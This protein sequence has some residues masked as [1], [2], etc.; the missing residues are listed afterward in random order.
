MPHIHNKGNYQCHTY[1]DNKQKFTSPHEPWDQMNTARRMIV[2]H[3][4]GHV[5]QDTRPHLK[6]QATHYKKRATCHETAT[7]TRHGPH[8]ARC[9]PV[10]HKT[11]HIA[12]T[13]A[14]TLQDGPHIT[15]MG[16]HITRHGPHITD[17]GL[18]ITR[19][20]PNITDMGLHIRRRVP[21]PHKALGTH[22]TRHGPRSARRG[23][24][25]TRRGPAHHN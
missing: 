8:S 20:G 3:Q 5:S 19:H 11:V 6:I 23:P 2:R 10:H 25:L 14:H 13:W 18:H 4:A 7:F 22:I 17:V 21:H 16:R 1:I 9:G 12:Q 15:D 24:Y